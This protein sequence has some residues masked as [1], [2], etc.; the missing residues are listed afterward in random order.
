MVARTPE[1]DRRRAQELDER[2]V[3]GEGTP[4]EALES[5]RLFWPAYFASR[6][7]VMPF[8]AVRFS[9]GLTLDSWTRH[10]THSASRTGAHTR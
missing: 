4:E 6:E 1:N 3:R 5:L 10:R 9:V 8:P 2:A 7:R